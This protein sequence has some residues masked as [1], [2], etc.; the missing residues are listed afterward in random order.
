V[1][2][3]VEV[4]PVLTRLGV[5][6]VRGLLVDVLWGGSIGDASEALERYLSFLPAPPLQRSGTNR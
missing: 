1:L 5:A 4:D 3:D 6:V 2:W